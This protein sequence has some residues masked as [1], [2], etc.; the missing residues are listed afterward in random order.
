MGDGPNQ[1]AGQDRRNGPSAFA[2]GAQQQEGGQ[3]H[4]RRDPDPAEPAL[5]DRER[6]PRVGAEILPMRR[7]VTEAGGCQT[8]ED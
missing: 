1:G 3:D 2:R 5:P 4:D 8:A 6:P 7:H